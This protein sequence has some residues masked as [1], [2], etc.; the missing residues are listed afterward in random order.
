MAAA[1]SKAKVRNHQARLRFTC[2][3]LQSINKANPFNSNIPLGNGLHLKDLLVNAVPKG[4]G[5]YLEFAGVALHYNDNGIMF[6]RAIYTDDCTGK[7]VTQ[8]FAVH[9]HGIKRA[10]I[11]AVIA[12]ADRCGYTGHIPE[13]LLY[14]PT[15]KELMQYAVLTKGQDWVTANAIEDKLKALNI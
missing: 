9:K 15:A 12:R 2:D 14:I 13:D 3:L 5:R 10:F 1:I 4:D 8:S 11:K 7:S 6:I